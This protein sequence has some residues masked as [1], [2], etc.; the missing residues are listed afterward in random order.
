M[1]P[2]ALDHRRPNPGAALSAT[3]AVVG[4]V[5]GGLGLFALVA[6]GLR[7]RHGAAKEGMLDDDPVRWRVANIACSA[8]TILGS[9][10][11]A[12]LGAAPHQK[13]RAVSGS[14]IGATVVVLPILAINPRCI[15]CGWWYVGGGSLGAAI[16]AAVGTAGAR[17]DAT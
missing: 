2:Y 12:Y 13:P 4:G 14:M 10:Y 9:A 8:G 7:I 6:L 11:G 15:G 5:L 1:T 17:T 3:G 16:G